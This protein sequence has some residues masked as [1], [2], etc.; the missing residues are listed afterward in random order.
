MSYL[1]PV[2]TKRLT[3]AEAAEVLATTTRTVHRLV[4]PGAL[5]PAVRFPGA[6]GPMMFDRT[7]VARLAKK[8]K[9]V[10]A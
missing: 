9:K 5:V 1:R 4:E 10:S 3:T 7:D 6:R 8:R 2:P